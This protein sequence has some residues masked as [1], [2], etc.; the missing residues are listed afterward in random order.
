[1]WE[2]TINGSKLTL[3]V[4]SG[5]NLG[6][7]KIVMVS[8]GFVNPLAAQDAP[9]H[10]RIAAMGQAGGV[11]GGGDTMTFFEDYVD[12][13]QVSILPFP[14][15]QAGDAQ[16]FFVVPPGFTTIHAAQSTPYGGYTNTIS[17]SFATSANLSAALGSHITVHGLTGNQRADSQQLVIAGGFVDTATAGVPQPAF[18]ANTNFAEGLLNDVWVSNENGSRWQ[19]HNHSQPWAV[20]EGHKLV[21]HPGGS[22]LSGD[23]YSS[24]IFLIGGRTIVTGRNIYLSDVWR[25]VDNG[26]SWEEMDNTSSFS[27]RAWGGAAVSE[28]RLYVGGGITNPMNPLNDLYYSTTGM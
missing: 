20:R 12:F 3:T 21:Y 18:D 11:V 22:R 14:G 9:Q 17:L 10:V 13:D 6:V 4:A 25:S 1:M 28:G 26:A 24:A 23:G 16:P 19:L 7:G 8:V 15:S 2:S 27:P 5:E